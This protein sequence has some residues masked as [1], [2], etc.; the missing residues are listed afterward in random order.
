MY[1]KSPLTNVHLRIASVAKV[2]NA[3]RTNVLLDLGRSWMKSMRKKKI[4]QPNMT[5]PRNLYF[6]ASCRL[7]KLQWRCHRTDFTAHLWLARQNLEWVEI[8]SVES[9]ISCAN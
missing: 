4:D 5:S 6:P 1:K 9:M 8:D 7:V 3:V 2:T